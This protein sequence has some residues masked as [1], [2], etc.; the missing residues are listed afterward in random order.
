MI[1]LEK[2]R[3]D[4]SLMSCTDKMI[5]MR[6]FKILFPLIFITTL[7]KETNC[8]NK[9]L[10]YKD[11]VHNTFY[12]VSIKKINNRYFVTFDKAYFGK[13]QLKLNSPHKDTIYVTLG[14]KKTKDNRVDITPP[15]TIRF[16]FDTL[17]IESGEH[18][19]SVDIPDFEPPAW[20]KNSNYY[21][22]LP[23]SIGNIMPFR[24]VDISG[25]NGILELTDIQQTGYFYPFNDSAS[26][27]RTSSNEINKIWNLC[28][29]TMKATSF[30][31]VYIDGDRERRPYEADAYI[32]QLSHYAVDKEY[33][34]ARK[35]IDHLAEFPTWP[36][37]WLF[38][39]PMMLWEDYMYTG[40]KDYLQKYYKHYK[41]MILGLPVNSNGL[42]LNHNNNDII[43]WPK[44]ERD[45]YQ[46][47]NINNVPNAFYYNSLVILSKI[48]DVLG[49]NDEASFLANKAM[50][51][52]EIFNH[53]FWDKGTGLYIDAAD[54]THSSI[55]ANIF[56]VVFGLAGQNQID[57]IM[58]FIK[59]K[60]MATSVY[61][62]QYL[63]DM[64]YMVNEP[65]YAF[66]L[67]TAHNERSWMHMI[68]QG[69]TITL[70][71][72]DEKV[73]GNLDWNHAW[74]AAPGNIIARRVF[75]IRPL[76]S[77]FKTALIEPQFNGLTKGLIKQPTINGEIEI[78]FE[79][80][81]ETG[82]HLQIKNDM[83]AQFV[84]P[85]EYANTTSVYLNGRSI[86]PEPIH[87][88]MTIYLKKGENLIEL[89]K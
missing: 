33:G 62:A 38:H 18:S 31:G 55:H 84:L 60:G 71:A 37:E 20:A 87:K 39:M 3:N 25:Y 2:N 47:G 51:F 64:L 66:K 79:K 52:K 72:W 88:Q 86:K 83:P 53:V 23:A 69:S 10:E 15:G 11:I 74:G 68:G 75:G 73:K 49:R 50:V 41:E 22:P 17:V 61:G 46:V 29:H 78:A 21:I 14:E 32:N 5:N 89:K 45:G 26:V 81:G 43:D 6:Y 36:S 56:P 70:E 40:N 7:A 13:L 85:V 67:L 27:C 54:S 80:P 63:L 48:A 65:D 76:T 34:L 44:N 24:Y 1:N 57:K 59:S 35:T 12:P 4:Q 30:C 58:P 16:L 82:L 77:G 28:K 19:Y 42:V 8:Q 9:S